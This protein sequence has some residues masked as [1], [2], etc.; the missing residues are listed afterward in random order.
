M[1]TYRPTRAVL[2]DIQRGLTRVRLAPG[3]VE[4]LEQVVETLYR[5]RH[6]F[7]VGIYLV[8]GEK[9]VR[10]SFRGPEPPSHAVEL[11][12]GTVGTAA[13]TGVAMVI[14]DVSAD[15]TGDA[16]FSATGSQAVQP[17]KLV[18]RVLGAIEVQ[19][20][21]QQFR[22]EDRIL[23][24][25]VAVVL[26]RFLT[27]RGKYLVRREREFQESAEGAPS[28]AVRSAP[29]AEKNYSGPT[30]LRAVAGKQTAK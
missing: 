21:G 23:L 6:Y 24:K 20:S 22:P 26:G 27:G 19:T 2:A 10:S 5:G 17:I 28:R 16:L 15:S 4:P 14:E 18:T 29:Q 25:K 1:K 12:K 9:V 8:V 30:G 7:W 13:K 11:G 3:S